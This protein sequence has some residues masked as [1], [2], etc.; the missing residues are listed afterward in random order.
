MLPSSPHSPSQHEEAEALR[1]P[2]A[3]CEEAVIQPVLSCLW[4]INYAP[5]A[6]PAKIPFSALSLLSCFQARALCLSVSLITSSFCL[7]LCFS[8]CWCLYIVSISD[9]PFFLPLSASFYVFLSRLLSAPLSAFS[10]LLPGAAFLGPYSNL[11]LLLSAIS[12]KC[13]FEK[14]CLK[15]IHVVAHGH[16]SSFSALEVPRNWPPVGTS[17]T[18]LLPMTLCA[19]LRTSPASSPWAHPDILCWAPGGHG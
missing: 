5:E 11:G 10:F 2:G 6:S 12:E 4:G 3:P 19:K 18:T 9:F 17:E 8:T 16:G 14:L 1:G 15:R 7:C 13:S